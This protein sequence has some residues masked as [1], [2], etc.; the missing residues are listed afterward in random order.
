MEPFLFIRLDHPHR[1]QM[2]T[3]KYKI[4]KNAVLSPAYRLTFLSQGL[5]ITLLAF[6]PSL[7]AYPSCQSKFNSP[8]SRAVRRKALSDRDMMRQERSLRVRKMRLDLDPGPNQRETRV[9]AV[10]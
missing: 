4:D 2:S 10:S 7:L 5:S 1:P 6:Q 9:A 3:Q 8:V